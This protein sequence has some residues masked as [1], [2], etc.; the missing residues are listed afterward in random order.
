MSRNKSPLNI[1]TSNYDKN[2]NNLNQH[3]YFNKE[4]YHNLNN[5]K[6]DVQIKSLIKN[7][8]GELLSSK[9][10]QN[11]ILKMA[12][13]QDVKSLALDKLTII[14]NK[15]P[16]FINSQQ[17]LKLNPIVNITTLSN[18]NGENQI[19]DKYETPKQKSINLLYNQNRQTFS[20]FGLL[21]KNQSQLNNL[22]PNKF[23][24][25]IDTPQQPRNQFDL[26]PITKHNLY[27]NLTTTVTPLKNKKSANM[28]SYRNLADNLTPEKLPQMS[29]RVLQNRDLTPNSNQFRMKYINNSKTQLNLQENISNSNYSTLMQNKSSLS[30]NQP[31]K[32]SLFSQKN[33]TYSQKHTQ[34]HN[35]K[36][37]QITQ[38]STTHIL[39]EKIKELIKF[40]AKTFVMKN[41][42]LVKDN[43][44]TKDMLETV[45]LQKQD[46]SDL[47]YMK[48]EFY[49]K[50]EQERRMAFQMFKA[51]EYQQAINSLEEIIQMSKYAYDID[52]LSKVL[53]LQAQI[54][55]FFNDF[56]GAVVI[57]KI[58]RNVASDEGNDFNKMITYCDLGQCYNQLKEYENS[59]K[60]YKKLLELAWR[61]ESIQFEIK[62]YEQLG[63]Q[64]Y[65]IGNIEKSQ[66]YND[67]AMRGKCEKKDSKIR[68]LYDGINHQLKKSESKKVSYKKLKQ[69]LESFTA[70]KDD[71]QM[72]ESQKRLIRT[73]YGTGN[74]MQPID[75][76]RN[77]IYMNENPLKLRDG[78]PISNLSMSQLPSPRI[79]YEDNKMKNASLLPHYSGN[80]D[81]NLSRR[82]LNELRVQRN[83][84]KNMQS[85]SSMG[86]QSMVENL[87]KD[88]SN[89]RS[90]RS[91]SQMK[92]QFDQ[93]TENI[94]NFQ[95]KKHIPTDLSPKPVDFQEI[96]KRALI[97]GQKKKSF[98]MINHLSPDR[99]IRNQKENE[100]LK[101]LDSMNTF[102]TF[103]DE[104]K[105]ELV[106]SENNFIKADEI[107]ENMLLKIL[108][109]ER[110]P[111]LDKK[112]SLQ[113]QSIIRR[114]SK[115][116]LSN[117]SIGDNVSSYGGGRAPSMK[118]SIGSGGVK[119]QQLDIK[120]LAK[121]KFPQNARIRKYNEQLNNAIV[122]TLQNLSKDQPLIPNSKFNNQS[123]DTSN[124]QTPM[125]QYEKG[126]YVSKSARQI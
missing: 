100:D 109:S 82:Q 91:Q 40:Q 119:P 55:I 111:T 72:Q 101:Q 77:G 105:E 106:K 114:I 33:Q 94:Q 20:S 73:E 104:I 62:A 47:D 15:T 117:L 29:H 5:N 124:Y 42:K 86:I 102:Q 98:Q 3:P 107:S 31:H 46:M 64:Y 24:K 71:L 9:Y 75:F 121:I 45:I 54:A 99:N 80:D 70:L 65:Y 61:L 103:E 25:E 6:S 125:S 18:K 63:I 23:L 120:V 36:S 84:S 60:C 37:N 76:Y 51:R 16:Q 14:R 69:I 34:N 39:S 59:I 38:Q 89:P 126:L 56:R 95:I 44:I 66:Y 118:S 85:K 30:I 11:L 4:S 93:L 52:L 96:V 48:R 27:D 41:K 13:Q 112:S 7:E 67:R 87:G 21:H 122:K 58:I 32:P 74:L 115:A 19:T 22:N 92:K 50:V 81:N 57:Y 78:S 79:I 113:I 43:E 97:N 10:K 53:K 26:M 1:Q 83:K 8:S 90:N 116:N 123:M 110:R 49:N 17:V 2:D 108:L 28:F 68:E 12:D 35:Q 88:N